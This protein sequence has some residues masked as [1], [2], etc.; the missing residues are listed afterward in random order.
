MRAIDVMGM[1]NGRPVGVQRRGD[2]WAVV[3]RDGGGDPLDDEAMS[4]V[5][6]TAYAAAS[7][8][9]NTADLVF[10]AYRLRDGKVAFVSGGGETWGAYTATERGF[11]APLAGVPPCATANRARAALLAWA[12]ANAAYIIDPCSA[13][14]DSAPPS[15][16][17][18]RSARNGA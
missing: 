5:V 10:S 6:P 8:L 15:P 4:D 14:Q 11:L 7:L 1:H 16:S 2:G 18:E 12:M 3:Y 9:V 17:P 13:L